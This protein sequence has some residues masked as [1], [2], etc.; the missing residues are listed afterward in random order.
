MGGRLVVISLLAA[1]LTVF[2][3]TQKV[4]IENQG[5]K[6]GAW[7]GVKVWP[8]ALLLT[9]ACVSATLGICTSL[10]EMCAEMGDSG[11]VIVLLFREL[12]ESVCGYECY[13]EYYG[14]ARR[15]VL[16]GHLSGS[17]S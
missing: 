6:E 17:V 12:G 8:A 5:T 1:N 14:V 11:F 15:H 10:P 3:E 16:L 7:Q 13:V 9:V 2:F 4:L